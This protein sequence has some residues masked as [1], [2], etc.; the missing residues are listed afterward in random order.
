MLNPVFVL[1]RET[2]RRAVGL[3]PISA[4][5]VTERGDWCLPADMRIRDRGE[6][7]DQRRAQEDEPERFVRHTGT[8]WRLKGK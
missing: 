2:V 4:Y 6:L 7:A 3:L 1:I 8:V 5:L